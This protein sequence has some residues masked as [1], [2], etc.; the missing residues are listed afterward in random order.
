MDYSETF[1]PVV[2][3]TTV[4]IVLCLALFMNG[5]ITEEVYMTQPPGFTN[6][7]RPSHV[8][9]LQKALCGLKQVPRAWYNA[10]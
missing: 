5:T 9:H 3:P 7:T 8:C 1:S 10:L 2:K 6:V 4:R